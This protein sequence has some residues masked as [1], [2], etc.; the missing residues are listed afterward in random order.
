[1]PMPLA[2]GSRRQVLIDAAV[3]AF[4]RKGYRAASVSDI[5]DRAGVARGT[6]YLYFD[7]KTDVFLAVI[8]RFHTRVQQMLDEPEGPIRLTEH[9]GRAMLQRT[10]RR[11]LQLFVERRDEARVILKEATSI[12][13]RFDEA[14]AALRQR[15]VTYFTD[16]FRRFQALGLVDRSVPPELLAHFQL[17]IV[18]AL[19]NAFVLQS[20][21]V[22]LDDLARQAAVF[23]WQGI[24]PLERKGI[25][26]RAQT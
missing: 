14:V 25:A 20:D 22:D 26:V 17:G 4:A 23:E 8:D 16:R 24:Q 15:G 18:D 11:W 13:P 2:N 10:I 6:F 19:V 1:M 5:I 7:G 3:W 9:N 21:A 12:D